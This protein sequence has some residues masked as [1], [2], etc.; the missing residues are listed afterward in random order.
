M[1]RAGP[2]RVVRPDSESKW[3]FKLLKASVQLASRLSDGAAQEAAPVTSWARP[4][5]RDGG[6]W[7]ACE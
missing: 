3:E 5:A 1:S 4:A 6:H 2:A 7:S